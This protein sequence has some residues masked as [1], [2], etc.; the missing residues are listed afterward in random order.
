VFVSL[1]QTA[2]AAAA[3]AAAKF[4]ESLTG[5]HQHHSRSRASA[6]TVN[7]PSSCRHTNRLLQPIAARLSGLY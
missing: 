6:D 2:A 5:D 7:A 3:A 1:T 4:C